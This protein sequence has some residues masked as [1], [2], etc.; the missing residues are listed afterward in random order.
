[1]MDLLLGFI[2]IVKRMQVLWLRFKDFLKIIGTLTVIEGRGLSNIHD[3]IRVVKVMNP[4]VRLVR[5]VR[6]VEQWL[7]SRAV[8]ELHVISETYGF[9]SYWSYG[10]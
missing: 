5:A 6:V 8:D 4:P 2:I 9:C 7:T 1:M 3:L 10:S